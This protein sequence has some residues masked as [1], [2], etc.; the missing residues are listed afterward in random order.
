MIKQ[1][2]FL[3]LLCSIISCTSNTTNN[4][5]K[6]PEVEQT[7]LTEQS[8]SQNPE[9][10]N[11]LIKDFSDAKVQ[12][13]PASIIQYDYKGQT[14]YYVSSPCCDQYNNLYDKSKT[15]VCSPSG[16]ITGKGDGKCPD[17][18]SEKKNEKIIWADTRK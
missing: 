11:L 7:K 3:G 1:T 6:T 17:F 4:N 8:Q 12:N 13:P 15:L 10:V 5:T 14:V 18:D 16:G 2:L 9:W